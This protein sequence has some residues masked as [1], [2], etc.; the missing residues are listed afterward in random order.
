MTLKKAHIAYYLPSKDTFTIKARSLVI[1]FAM[2]VNKYAH[3][4][5]VGLEFIISAFFSHSHLLLLEDSG[6]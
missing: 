5:F 6:L 2:L 3:L 4:L 1:I